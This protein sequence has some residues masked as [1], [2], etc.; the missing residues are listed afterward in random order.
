MTA[1]YVLHGVW[2]SGP[3][4][5]VGLM[6]SLAGEPFDYVHVDLMHGA[7]KSPE[8]LARN[9]FGQV[10]CL[11]DA[12]NGRSLCQSASILDYLADTTGKFGGA[13]LEE[14]ISAREWMFWDFDRLAPNIYRTRAVKLGFR[15]AHDAVVDAQVIDAGLALKVLDTHLA[16]R[17]WI[18]GE[19]T[20]IADIDVYGVV[21]Y[22]PA[23]GFDLAAYPNVVAWMA[24]IEA[25]PGYSG[26]DQLLPKA[27]KAA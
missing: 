21:A 18:V 20:T 27:S 14:R 5:K 17:G 24:R 10:P 2:A 4:Y 11:V 6:L 16:G 3:T 15:K 8:F 26:P 9:R 13:T 1:R 23:A 22:A 19:G 25:L 7:H 12:S